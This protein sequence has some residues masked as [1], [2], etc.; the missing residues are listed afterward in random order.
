MQTGS[1]WNFSEP[2]VVVASKCLNPYFKISVPIFCCL[3]FFTEYDN[4]QSRIN[5]MVNEYRVNFH[6]SFSSGLISKYS[7]S[8]FFRPPK[9]FLSFFHTFYWTFSW[10]CISCHDWVKFSSFWCSD[11]WK[12]YLRVKKLVEIFSYVPFFNSFFLYIYL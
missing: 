6:P 10:I 1:A 5:T 7:V 8:Y 4:P 2:P 3:F 12:I 9:V 11:H